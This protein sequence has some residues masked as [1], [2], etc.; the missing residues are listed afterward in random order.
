MKKITKVPRI[1]ADLK[2]C[3]ASLIGIISPNLKSNLIS[4]SFLFSDS[5]KNINTNIIEK[6]LTP[7]AKKKGTEKLIDDSNPQITGPKINPAPKT[8]LE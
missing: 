8:A 5:G 6:R 4:L 7:A 2:N 1:L 3:L